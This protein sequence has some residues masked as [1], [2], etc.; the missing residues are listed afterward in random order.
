[1]IV[2]R[3]RDSITQAWFGPNWPNRAGG[4]ICFNH[5]LISGLLHY[6]TKE[7]GK[8]FLGPQFHWVNGDISELQL[9]GHPWFVRNYF[10]PI[11]KGSHHQNLFWYISCKICSWTQLTL[12]RGWK[13]AFLLQNRLFLSKA[14]SQKKL[15]LQDPFKIRS[16][17]WHFVVVCCCSCCCCVCYCCISCETQ[18]CWIWVSIV[19]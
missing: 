16:Q 4:L 7:F 6:C 13:I 14:R 2:S 10:N 18:L 3:L 17:P 15:W 9:S 11:L 8:Q 19:A 12:S 1:M 5:C